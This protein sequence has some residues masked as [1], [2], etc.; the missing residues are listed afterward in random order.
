[1]TL[2]Y[3]SYVF[4]C[5]FTQTF[6]SERKLYKYCTPQSVE[7]SVPH[8][9]CLPFGASVYFISTAVLNLLGLRAFK[10]LGGPKS[11]CLCKLYLSTFATIEIILSFKILTHF[12]IPNHKPITCYIVMLFIKITVFSKRKVR[13]VAWFYSFANFFNDCF[14]RRQLDS[15]VC[16]CTQTVLI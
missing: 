5:V 15:Y 6:K 11:F 14:N 10:L 13:R 12:K 1:M 9:L 3:K 2:Y 16:L 4:I 8:R 7:A